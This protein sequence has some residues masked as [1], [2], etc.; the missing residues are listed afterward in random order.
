[1]RS[2]AAIRNAKLKQTTAIKPH[3]SAL[4]GNFMSGFISNMEA[5]GE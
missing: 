1:M 4:R 3:I 5:P 2:K